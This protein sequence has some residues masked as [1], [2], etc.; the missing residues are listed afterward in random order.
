M[1]ICE[2]HRKHLLRHWFYC[3]V[4]VFRALLR[5]W[6]TFHNNI[7]QLSIMKFTTHKVCHDILFVT[8]RIVCSWDWCSLSSRFWHQYSRKGLL[9]QRLPLLLWAVGG[10]LNPRLRQS[11]MIRFSE[12]KYKLGLIHFTCRCDKPNEELSVAKRAW[13][14][15]NKTAQHI[16]LHFFR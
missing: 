4:R 1:D 13:G 8:V 2:P 6:S 16:L 11:N 12:T 10:M 15:N 7:T 3:C 9:M 5:N 14:W